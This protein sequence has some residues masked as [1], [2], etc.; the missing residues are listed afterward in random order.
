MNEDLTREIRLWG[1]SCHLAALSWAPIALLAWSPGHLF[2][3]IPFINIIITFGLWRWRRDWHDFIDE[4]GRESLNFQI[5]QLIYGF[6]TLVLLIF[7]VFVSCGVSLSVGNI[8]WTGSSFAL[9]VMASGLFILALVL[10]QLT[11]SVFAAVKA[12]QGQSYR[13]PFTIRFLN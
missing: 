9:L 11:L 6:I 8:S 4:Q 2:V 5:S 3:P 12:I 13:Y 7:L 10:F 1:M